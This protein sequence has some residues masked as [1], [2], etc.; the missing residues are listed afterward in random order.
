MLLKLVIKINVLKKFELLKQHNL[1]KLALFNSQI[2]SCT[3]ANLNHCLIFF[4]VCCSAVLLVAK[5][6]HRGW[7]GAWL[8]SNGAMILMGKPKYMEKNLSHCYCP[9][10]IPHRLAREQIQAFIVRGLCMTGWAMSQPLLNIV[11]FLS[12]LGTFILIV[13]HKFSKYLWSTSGFWEPEVWN[14]ASYILRTQNSGVALNFTV[15]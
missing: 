4:W 14:V 13:V 15:I 12:S 11:R 9:L 1:K 5:N 6:V 7:C 2:I 8:W 3:A 10:Q